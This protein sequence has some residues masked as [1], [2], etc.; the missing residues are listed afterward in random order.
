MMSHIDRRDFVKAGAAAVAGFAFPTVAISDTKSSGRVLGSNERIRVAVAGIHGRGKAHLGSFAAMKKDAEVIYLCDPDSSLFDSRTEMVQKAGGNTPLCVQ[1]VRKAL[2][3]PSVDVVSIATPNH[4]HSLIGIWAC[5]AG[6][7]VYVE[8][9]LSHNLFEG[10][11]LVE[12]SR[13]YKRVVQ[14]GTQQ[15]SSTSRA[16]EIAALQ[17]GKYGKLL[18]SRGYCCKPRWSIGFKEITDPPAALDFDIWLG[19]APKQGYHGNLVHYNWHWFWDFGNGDTG[20][21][22]VHEMDVARW[23]IKGATLPTKIWSLGGRFGYKDQGQTPNTQLAVYEYGDVLLVFETRGLVEKHGMKEK[24]FPF[25]VHNEY[26]TTEGMIKGGKFYPKGGG[27][28]ESVS[29]GTPDPII[30]GGAFGSFLRSVRGRKIEDNN[31]PAEVGHYSAALCHLANISYRLGKPV[32]FNKKTKALGDNKQ[33]VESFERIQ[34]NLRAAGVDLMETQYV[35]GRTLHMDPKSERFVGD[36]EANALR[37]RPYRKGYV[38]P[39][40]V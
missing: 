23:A 5:Q 17:S 24:G 2:E 40:K 22:G 34:A 15:R 20:N 36:K 38:V 12:A 16:K 35:L 8:K 29:G 27:K 39:E 3:N 7:D 31:A 6:K 30:D 1:D 26:F 32:P 13:K 9:P 4:W 19:P 33:V 28:A 21:Q 11:K 25:M 37:T 18:V 10:R 14:H